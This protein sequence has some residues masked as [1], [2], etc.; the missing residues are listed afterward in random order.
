[1]A[2]FSTS[3]VDALPRVTAKTLEYGDPRVLGWLKEWVQEGD[4]INRADPSYDVIGRAQA[5]IV[6]EQLSD[7]QRKLKYLP[8]VVINETRKSMQAHVSAL[9][10]L[11]PVFGWK[12]LNP[13]Y[14]AANDQLNMYAVAEYIT[15]MADLDI[16]DTIKYSL[17]GGTGDMVIDWDPHAPLGGA[18]QY[19]ARDP[20]DT[21]PLRPSLGRSAQ[22]WEGVCF[23]EEHT[24][25]ALRGMY[26]ERAN[27]FMAATEVS[28]GRVMGRFRQGLHRLLTPSDPLDSI[29]GGPASAGSARKSRA[30]QLV[31]Y[32]AYFTDRTRNLT[33]KPIVMGRP[34][35]NWAYTVQ[36]GDP[37][38]PRKRLLVATDNFMIYDGPNTY[39]H[40]MLPFCRLKLWSVPWQFLGVPLFNDLLPVQEAI[41]ETAHDLRLAFRQ[42]VDPDVVYNRN[43]VSES[44]MRLLDPRRPGK[45]VRVQPGFGDPYAKQDGPNPQVMSFGL[46]LWRELTQKFSDLSGTANL[47]QLMQL[48][49]LPSADTIQKYY[50]AL[51]PEIRSE[52]RSVELFL[53]DLSEMQKVNYFQFL[54]SQ[55]RMQILGQGGALL[56][57]FDYDP[58]TLVPALL[59]NQPGYTPELDART[60]TRDQRA[61]WIHKSF[62]FVVS[63]N[64]VLAMNA[65]EQKM[66]RLQLARMGYYDFW[67]LHETLETP[68]VGA[69]PAVPLP[70]L[71]PPPPGVV[72]AMLGQLV[73][74]PGAMQGVVA[75]AMGIPQYTDESTGRTFILEPQGGQLLELRLPVTVTERLQ[76]QAM[77]GLGQT[78]SPAG[79]KASGQSPPQME[80]KSDGEGGSRSTVSESE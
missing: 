41:N 25:N 10:D 30:G 1:M 61:Q 79:R 36:P 38:Y 21:L 76:A 69:P 2:E 20:R 26:P 68:N 28:L 80:E 31:L 5:Y 71:E 57:D 54:S 51:T 74:T 46:E 75:G 9:T 70:P 55:K 35:T 8:Q 47:A 58:D 3:D 67:S 37:L 34:G 53:R 7:T 12:S 32:R 27:L 39:W 65:Q 4:L 56:S 64:S 49:Q 48:R 33:D 66:L 17:A 15:T 22:L 18:H 52:A 14:Q 42:W 16:G 50:E 6:G 45:R 77:L 73:N 63:P 62:V 72:E 11:K 44:T 59:P 78:V 24:V 40:G 23:R 29:A 60:T 43:A 19:T 13:A